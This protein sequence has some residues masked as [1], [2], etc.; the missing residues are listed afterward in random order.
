M[1]VFK[2]KGGF[3]GLDLVFGREIEICRVQLLLYTR[4]HEQPIHAQRL[5]RR[6]L[7]VPPLHISVYIVHPQSYTFSK[8]PQPHCKRYPNIPFKKIP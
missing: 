2:Q 4:R 3:D 8:A 7:L 1:Q 6:F 5:Q